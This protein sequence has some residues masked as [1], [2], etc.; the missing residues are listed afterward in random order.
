MT[1]TTLVIGTDDPRRPA[2]AARAARAHAHS[3]TGRRGAGGPRRSTDGAAC[4][5][6]SWRWRST[7]TLRS[8]G[9]RKE[10][11]ALRYGAH[12]GRHGHRLD[13][14]LP[15]GALGWPA[16]HPLPD[17]TVSMAARSVT[18]GWRP[19]PAVPRPTPRRSFSCSRMHSRRG[20]CIACASTPMCATSARGP[21][22]S[23]SARNSK[24]CCAHIDWLRISARAIR[25]A[26]PIVAAE[27][28]RLKQRL[29][30]RLTAQR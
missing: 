30:Q 20:V 15:A 7:S 2:R 14:L 17:V 3:R 4:R 21:L 25:R 13:A 1:D 10:C 12:R 26:T 6:A 16:G 19:Q 9:A 8:A 5:R 28:P 27:W 11:V 24:G 29:Q 18:P 23:A 22:S